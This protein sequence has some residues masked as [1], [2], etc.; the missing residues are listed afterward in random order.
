MAQTE[1]KD[2]Q[3]SPNTETPATVC[4][5][6]QTRNKG[7]NRK[8]CRYWNGFDIIENGYV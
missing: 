3:R 7:L 8:N 5:N 6:W 4:E 2:E 1:S